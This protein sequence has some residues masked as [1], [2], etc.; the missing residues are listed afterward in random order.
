MKALTKEI[1][2]KLAGTSLEGYIADRL[3][4]GR[5]IE[6]SEYPFVEFAVVDGNPEYTMSE[7][8]EDVTIQFDIF[9]AT[10]SADEVEDIFTALTDLYDN[11]VLTP[12]SE[13]GIYMWRS[14]FNLISEEHTVRVATQQ[15]W[16]YSIDYNILIQRT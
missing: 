8:F 5:S 4:K 6:S 9:S 16:H 15:V 13:T 11:A 12:T 10:N 1:Y 2:E 7:N 14:N 3:Y